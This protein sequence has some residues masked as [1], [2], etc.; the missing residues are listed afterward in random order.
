MH[1]TSALNIEKISKKFP[2]INSILSATP[3]ILALCCASFIL[4]G[5]ISMAITKTNNFYQNLHNNL[6]LK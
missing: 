5:S 6:L 3:Y 2:T 4:N 1:I